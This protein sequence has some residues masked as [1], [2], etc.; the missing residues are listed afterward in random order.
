MSVGTALIT[1]GMVPVRAKLSL[2]GTDAPKMKRTLEV[3]P[4]I[5]STKITDP[6]PI[7]K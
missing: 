4:K 2:L 7:M 5:R 6:K 1:R 3:R